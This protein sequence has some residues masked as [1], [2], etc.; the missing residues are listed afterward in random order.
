MPYVHWHSLFERSVGLV[1]EVEGERGGVDGNVV[2]SRKVLLP[3]GQEPLRE[4]ETT[5]PEH[6]IIQAVPI[7][8]WNLIVGGRA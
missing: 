1:L 5:N 3:R 8:P 2:L 4:V 7:N 6:L